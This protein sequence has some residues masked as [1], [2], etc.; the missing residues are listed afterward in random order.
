MEL[1]FTV[2]PVRSRTMTETQIGVGII[3]VEPGRSWSAVAHNPC[4]ESGSRLSNRSTEYD[5]PGNLGCRCPFF[6]GIEDAFDNY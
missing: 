5:A 1:N 2:E 6:Y 4:L 3:G